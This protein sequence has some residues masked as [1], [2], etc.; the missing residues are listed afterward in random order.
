MTPA[1]FGRADRSGRRPRYLSPASGKAPPG[2][3]SGTVVLT[4]DGE[5]PV[6]FLTPGDRI[7]TRD[8]GLVRLAG[9]AWRNVVARLIL[10]SAGSLGHRRPD[11]DLALP[12]D[13]LVLIRDWRATALAGTAQALLPARALVDGEFVRD[14]GPQPLCLHL[15]RFARPQVIY[16]GGMELAATAMDAATLHDAA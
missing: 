11:R 6:E 5:I 14:L 1:P 9:L 10:F 13:Q 4:A 3:L 15:L 12:A 8:T 16:A 7:I 2:I